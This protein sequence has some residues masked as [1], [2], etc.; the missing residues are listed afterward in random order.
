MAEKKRITCRDEEG[1]SRLMPGMSIMTA[2]EALC[3]L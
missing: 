1:H 2:V 3:R